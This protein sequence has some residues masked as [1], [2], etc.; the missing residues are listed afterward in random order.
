MPIVGDHDF[1]FH[2]TLPDHKS[3]SVSSQM[4]NR[5]V[6]DVSQEESQF[7]HKEMK[8]M[9]KVINRLEDELKD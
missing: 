8:R 4:V 9:H 2:R 7:G 1:T 3:G 5:V 6:M